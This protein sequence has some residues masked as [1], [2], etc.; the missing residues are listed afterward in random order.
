MFYVPDLVQQSLQK[1]LLATFN[2]HRQRDADFMTAR[3]VVSSGAPRAIGDYRSD[4][5]TSKK[6]LVNLV[7][8]KVCLFQQPTQIE[9]PLKLI[10]KIQTLKKCRIYLVSAQGVAIQPK[11][12]KFVGEP[13]NGSCLCYA[14]AC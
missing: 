9:V 12:P 11:E 6:L 1:L 14:H 10:L 7:K 4:Q 13:A 2:G 5:S 3:M 8:R